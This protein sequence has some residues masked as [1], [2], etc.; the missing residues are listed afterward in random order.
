MKTFVVCAALLG[1]FS[2]CVAEAEEKTS[3][4]DER[5]AKF[6]AENPKSDR[7]KDGVLTKDEVRSFRS[8]VKGEPKPEIAFADVEYG[9]HERQKFDVWL[10]NRSVDSVPKPPVLVFFHGGGF[11]AGDKSGF[12]PSP[13]LKAGIAVVSSNYRFV[14]GRDSL[15][16]VPL[17]DAARA[18][19][20]VRQRAD[21]WG[22]DGSRLAVSGSS[23]GAVIAL[24]LGYHDDLADPASD[25]PVARQSTRPTCIAPINGPTN[26]DPNWILDHLGGPPRVHGSFPKLFGA[27]V[28]QAADPEVKARITQA[29]PMHHLSADDVP[30]CLVYTGKDEGIPL[31]ATASSG[32]LIHHAHFG[33]LLA[34]KLD[35]LGLAHELH[36]GTDPRREP[37]IV[38]F[39]T[40]QL[41]ASASAAE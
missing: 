38:T 18:V 9:D 27:G 29:S 36:T 40:E 24:W 20:T 34:E 13:Y 32:V 4:N 15:S 12:D 7:D 22:I 19:Q 37:V 41:G 39:L 2:V 8:A 3:E 14:N 11:V 25:N 33:V 6:L 30:T 16:P 31:P 21:E 1:G 28:D 26:L 10:P 35:E 17:M 5:F 23:A